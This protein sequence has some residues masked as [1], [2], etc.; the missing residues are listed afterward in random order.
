[1]VAIAISFCIFVILILTAHAQNGRS[2]EL[3]KYD[4]FLQLHG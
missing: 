1:L 2:I 4:A 3:C